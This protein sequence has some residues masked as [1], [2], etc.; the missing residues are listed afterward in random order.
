[1]IRLFKIKDFESHP[2]AVGTDEVTTWSFLAELFGETSPE[3]ELLLVVVKLVIFCDNDGEV[4]YCS[5]N[6]TNAYGT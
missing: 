5:A 3:W 1:M 2:L 6:N 4:R